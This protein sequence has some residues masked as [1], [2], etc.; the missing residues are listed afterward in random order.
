MSQSI[1]NKSGSLTIA[2]SG[3]AAVAHITLETVSCIENADVIFY[4]CTDPVTEAFIRE[5]SKGECSDLSV[6]YDKDKHRYESYVQM[7][8]VMLN[9]TRAGKN[10]LGIFYGHPGVFVSPS[11]RAIAIARAEGY[12]ATMLPGVSAEDFLFSEI[13]FDP[14][15]PGCVS[16][17]ATYIV[18]QDK[19]LDPTV[20]NIIWQVGSVCAA[21]MVFDNSSFHLLVD[22][23]EKS[24]GN[25]HKL[26]HFIGPL[27]PQ[28]T[29]LKQELTISE[30]RGRQEKGFVHFHVLRSSSRDSQISREHHYEAWVV[31]SQGSAH[32]YHDR[33]QACRGHSRQALRRFRA[34]RRG[35]AQS[36]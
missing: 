35:E 17:E 21:A 3:I 34:W 18:L 15:V 2:G 19:A 9:A 27:L 10:V 1:T 22:K 7:C 31:P 20:H 36:V 29:S 12:R 23:L 4:V 5:R 24:F 6:Y 25:D 30:L 32:S 13:G 16:Q 33:F 26:I 11:H 8:E 14:A 28:S